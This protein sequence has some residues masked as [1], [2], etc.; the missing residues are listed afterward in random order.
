MTMSRRGLLKAAGASAAFAGSGYPI[1]QALADALKMP[2]A[3]L[4]GVRGEAVLDALPGKKPLIKL[5]YRPPNYETP[6]E[7][8]NGAIT[9][10]DTFFVRYHLSDI[11][12][13]IDPKTWKL[14]I[15]G[16]GMN[17]TAELTF[18][19]LKRLPSHEITAVCQCSGNRRGLF[20]PHV[21]GVQWG[22][23][24]MGCARWKGARLKDVLA[25]AGLKK[26]AIEIVFNAPDGPVAPKTPDF[27]KSIPVSKAIDDNTIIAYEMNGKPLPHWNGFPA[28]I[29]VPGWTATYW[30]KHVNAIDAITKP[31]DGFW[32]RSAYRIP[33][34]MFKTE[35]F[36]SQDNPTATPIT[37][38]VVNSIVT[39]H[40]DDASI[41]AGAPTT[42]SG[43]SWDSGSGIQ[44]VEYSTDNAKSWKDAKLGQDLGPFAFRTFSFST[45]SLSAGAHK[46]MVKATSKKGEMQV[47]KLIFN[48]AGYHHNVVQTLTL[49]A[50]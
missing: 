11:P 24:A 22:Y 3:L 37:Q 30:V 23:G 46:V 42:I 15:G 39:S 41:K 1:S 2:K 31:F 26:E 10:N 36:K 6:I 21:A 28:R 49:N 50:A 18:D 12:E 27:A 32:V 25:K 33:S 17:G 40:L 44:N 43:V 47:D 48:G 13:Q 16:D 29:V 20:S 19:Q 8:L 7:L 45:P 4:P 38:M 9:P 5:S 35:V 34:G 14:K